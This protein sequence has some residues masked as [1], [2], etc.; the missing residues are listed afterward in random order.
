M[1]ELIDKWGTFCFWGPGEICIINYL[2]SGLF[3][4]VLSVFIHYS[5]NQNCSASDHKGHKRVVN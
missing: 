3:I 5:T 1:L 2:I 4:G